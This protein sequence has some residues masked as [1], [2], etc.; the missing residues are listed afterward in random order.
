MFFLK[1]TLFK[2]RKKRLSRE[3]GDS[4]RLADGFIRQILAI[5]VV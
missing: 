2:A 4:G 5:A 1:Y 3:V